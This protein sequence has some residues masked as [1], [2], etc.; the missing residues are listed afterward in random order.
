MR[1][2]VKRKY[3]ISIYPRGP[4][5]AYRSIRWQRYFWKLY[6][7]GRGNPAAYPGTSNHGLGNAVDVATPRMAWALRQVGHKFGWSN[8]EGRRVDEWWHWVHVA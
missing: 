5:S 2:H 7:S 3:G 1:R 4:R 6:K 8:A